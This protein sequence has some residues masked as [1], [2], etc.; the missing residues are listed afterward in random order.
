MVSLAI[1]I[2]CFAMTLP[3][4]ENMKELADEPVNG[5]GVTDMR[6]DF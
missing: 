6:A 4:R 2:C 1:G 3:P 5:V